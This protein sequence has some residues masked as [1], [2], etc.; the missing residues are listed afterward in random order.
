MINIKQIK[1]DA[2]KSFKEDIS[3]I[4]G[5]QWIPVSDAKAAIGFAIT[6]T[7]LAITKERSNEIASTS[8]IINMVYEAIKQASAFGLENEVIGF[9]MIA[10]KSNPTLTISQALV[11]GLDEWDV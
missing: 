3:V 2:E 8:E 1:K 9:A 10:L 6:D 7:Q 11:S 4:N 5:V